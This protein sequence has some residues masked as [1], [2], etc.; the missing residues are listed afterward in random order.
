MPAIPETHRDLL[1]KANVVTL[2][3]VGPDGT[4]QLSA[5][6]A[7]LDDGHVRTSLWTG[8]Q[9]YRNIVAN[10]KVSLFVIDPTNPYRTLEVRGN[11]KITDDSDLTFLGRLLE[12]YGTD[13]EHFSGP[14]IDRVVITI[15][16][17]RVRT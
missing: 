7:M 6:W 14:Q 1:E 11:A 3:T 12:H 4:P 2:A 9:K 15:E 13:L 16:P 5:I 17:T 8:R 10:P